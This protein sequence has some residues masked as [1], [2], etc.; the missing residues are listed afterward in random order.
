MSSILQREKD[1]TVK[2]TIILPKDLVAKTTESVMNDVAKN[3]DIPGF[4]KGKAPKKLVEESINKQKL[5]EEVLKQLLPQAYMEAVNEHKIRPIMNPKIHVNKLDTGKDWEFIAT[6][7]EMPDVVLKDYKKRV[8]DVTAK[9]KIVIPG[10]E[11][12]FGDAPSNTAGGQGK[13]G[14]SMDEIMKAF[15]EEV[16]VTIPSILVEQETDRLLSQTLD[17]IKRLGLTLDQY[18]A[19]TGKSP[20]ALRLEYGTKARND[21]TFEFALQKLS[22]LEKIT[23]DE[24]EIEEALQ[25][26]K[27]SAER[28]HLEQNRY[29]LASILRQQKTLDFLKNL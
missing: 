29:L 15:L 8:Q 25:K 19:S 16:E 5:Q 1:G 27:D 20:E 13:Q 7:A 12:P 24:K 21:I 10:K 22:E 4:R 2:L 11:Q 9:S 14:P 3:A 17:E 28:A 6:T 23:I 18:L 26:A